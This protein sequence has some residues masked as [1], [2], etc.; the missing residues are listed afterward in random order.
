MLLSLGHRKQARNLALV[1][2]TASHVGTVLPGPAET[3]GARWA[4]RGPQG[5]HV[6]VAWLSLQHGSMMLT[7]KMVTHPG[8]M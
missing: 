4:L 5:K 6:L 2:A 7:Q 8:R 3:A 1:S